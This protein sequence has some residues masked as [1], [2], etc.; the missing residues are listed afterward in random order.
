MLLSMIVKRLYRDSIIIYDDK[1]NDDNN[2][3]ITI[4]IEVLYNILKIKKNHNKDKILTMAGS[5]NN[6]LAA[7]IMK[8]AAVVVI[9]IDNN[10]K[11]LNKIMQSSF[12]DINKKSLVV[13]SV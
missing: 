12:S 6:V 1:S 10:D 8:I 2:I 7:M 5:N 4:V 11:N 9:I 13:F 3:N